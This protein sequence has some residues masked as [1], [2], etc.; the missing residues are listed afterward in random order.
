MKNMLR[1]IRAKP[2]FYMIS[3]NPNV[4]LGSVVCSLY[5]RR[6]ALKDDYQ[7]NRMD[8]LAYTPVE[9]NYLK[10][11]AKT[12]ITPSRQNQFIPE[13]IFKNAPVRPIAITLKTNSIFTGSY[14]E[15]PFWQQQ[16]SLRQI[17]IFRS[18][19]CRF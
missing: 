12:F 2:N 17:R 1:L 3:E 8:M 9:F 15:N 10:T 6:V 4:C 14:T 7:K 18:A 16:I 11:L 13:N 5:T 19:K